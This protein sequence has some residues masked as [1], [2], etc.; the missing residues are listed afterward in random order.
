MAEIEKE[1]NNAMGYTWVV[2]E[3]VIVAAV[4]A[5]VVRQARP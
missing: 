1:N 2:V 4:E 5:E 3:V